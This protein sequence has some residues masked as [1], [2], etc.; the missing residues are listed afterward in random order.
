M[1]H[2]LSQDTTML[3]PS[4]VLF[5]RHLRRIWVLIGRGTR[6]LWI[7]GQQK[8]AAHIWGSFGPLSNKWKSCPLVKRSDSALII[9][10][11]NKPGLALLQGMMLSGFKPMTWRI[12][13]CTYSVSLSVGAR[14][15]FT[16]LPGLRQLSLLNSVCLH[17][18]LFDVSGI[19]QRSIVS[20]KGIHQ[21]WA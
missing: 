7:P 17:L 1:T 4:P 15:I 20:F 5:L 12:S 2:I 14:V 16:L 13:G 18:L 21:V 6:K 10:C 11:D 8:C 3:S 19:H 9:S